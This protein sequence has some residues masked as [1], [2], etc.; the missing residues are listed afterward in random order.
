M[1]Y[2]NTHVLLAPCDWEGLQTHPREKAVR[3]AEKNKVLYIEHSPRYIQIRGG[4]D[5]KNFTY[6]LLNRNLRKIHDNLYVV[7]PPP[8]LP[9]QF[10]IISRYFHDQIVRVMI[11]LSKELLLLSIR[12]ILKKLNW[13]TDYLWTWLPYDVH[14]IG[15]LGE[16]KSI[17]RT[18]DEVGE[19]MS[20]KEIKHIIEKLDVKMC[21]KVDYVLCSAKS[22]YDKRHHLNPETYFVPFG[23]NFKHFNQTLNSHPD[24]PHDWPRSSNNYGVIGFA[25]TIDW[26]FD[27]DLVEKLACNNKKLT[28]V[29]VGPYRDYGFKAL[30]NLCRLDNVFWLGEKPF[31]ILPNYVAHFDVGII[32]YKV[33]PDTNTMRIYKVFEY[34]ACGKPVISTDLYEIRQIGKAVNIANSFEEFQDMIYKSISILDDPDAI[35]QRVS[36]A[37]KLD[38]DNIYNQLAEIICFQ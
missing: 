7:T 9:L 34:L 13:K 1:E 24:K 25:G 18:F 5:N 22:Q 15:K 35:K 14:L 4:K 17:Y 2:I 8:M 38:W 12:Q 20:S 6:R 33:G 28:F 11:R 29:L 23:V 32:P 21:N 36:L 27:F 26:R 31:E 16:K 19:W 30:D 37:S 3:L 10:S